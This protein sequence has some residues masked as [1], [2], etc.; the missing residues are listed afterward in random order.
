ML[1]EDMQNALRQINELKARDRELEAKLLPAGAGKTDT[2]PTKQNITKCMVVGDS[3]LRNGGA[4][5]A[6]MIVECFPGIK[7]ELN[8]LLEFTRV[9][10]T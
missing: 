9:L 10:M 7:T 5:H 1:Q 8:R 6:D 3:M 4:E 2:V